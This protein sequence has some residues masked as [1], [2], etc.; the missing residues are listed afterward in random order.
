M[1]LFILPHARL[2]T[3]AIAVAVLLLW[4]APARAE[5]NADLFRDIDGIM[6]GLSE[7]TGWKVR[8]KVPAEFISKGELRAFLERRIREEVKPEDIR[9]E[10]L[11]LKLFGLV[12]ESFD[13]RKTTIDLLSEQAAAF[14]D[15]N[16]RRLSIIDMPGPAE[17]KKAALV[18][19]LA[20]ALADQQ[21]QLKK[22][23]R[24]SGE[25]DDAATARQAVMEGQATWLMWAYMNKEAG[26]QALVSSASLAAM[27]AMSGSTSAQYPALENAPLYL[28]ESL[29]FP[30]TKGLSFQNAVFEKLGRAA[31][32]EVFTRPPTSTRQI[33]HPNEYLTEKDFASPPLPVVAGEAQLKK[34]ADG[35]LG[36]FDLYLLMRQFGPEPDAKRAAAE[37]RG[38]VFRILETKGDKRPLLAFATS[39]SS[40]DAAREFFDRY[41]DIL[42]RKSTEYSESPSSVD[43]VNG[44]TPRGR[45]DLR[46]TGS[47]VTSIEGVQ[48]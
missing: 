23:I 1:K 48:P 25:N 16:K 44:R 8:R 38:G 12:P 37:W 30:Y 47:R 34:L 31:F 9:I 7:I 20:H 14:Y 45:F 27:D 24:H 18:H 32:S 15:P 3:L 19:E 39:W 46:L 41:H 26:G 35:N 10:E 2:R 36:E 40:P 11:A 42:R 4:T 28:R 6:S 13:L 17:D 29:L 43:T 21:F 33:L 22:Y 5:R